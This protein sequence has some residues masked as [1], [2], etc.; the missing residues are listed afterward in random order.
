[1]HQIIKDEMNKIG[2]LQ[3]SNFF[4]TVSLPPPPNQLTTIEAAQDKNVYSHFRMMGFVEE[5]TRN[6]WQWI[7]SKLQQGAVPGRQTKIKSGK[8]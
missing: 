6:I 4:S 8:L 2:S 3:H 1:M 5:A 7:H